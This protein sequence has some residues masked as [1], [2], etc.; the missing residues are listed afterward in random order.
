MAP[1]VTV[2][3][4]GARKGGEP[5]SWQT[6]RNSPGLEDLWQLHFSIV[7]GTDNNVPDRYIANVEGGRDGHFI[8]ASASTDGSFSIYNSRTRETRRYEAR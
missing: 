4:N 6:V 3:N 8:K 1:R 7:G 2:M 5:A